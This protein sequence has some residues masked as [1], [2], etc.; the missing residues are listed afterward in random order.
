MLAGIVRMDFFH[1]RI[2]MKKN[3]GLLVFCISMVALIGFGSC[4]SLN[5]KNYAEGKFINSLFLNQYD[6]SVAVEEQ[7]YV[8]VISIRTGISTIDGKDAGKGKGYSGAVLTN[9]MTIVPQGKH[10]F[11]WI[12]FEGPMITMTKNGE[13]E[14]ELE[15]GNYY[16]LTVEKTGVGSDISVSFDNLKNQTEPFML[17]GKTADTGQKPIS[18]QS[19]IEGMNAK[20]KNKFPNFAPR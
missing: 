12:L 13:L 1:R 11:S 4:V 19:I 10:T 7:C 6:S 14:V 16:F 9:S 18:A 8:I 5:D 2:K 3:L 20:I 17:W 15:A